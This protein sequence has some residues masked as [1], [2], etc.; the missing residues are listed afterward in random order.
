MASDE[1]AGLA[2]PGWLLRPVGEVGLRM[3]VVSLTEAMPSFPESSVGDVIAG[4]IAA[5]DEGN[6][7]A[8]V[9]Q[10]V[11]DRR[12]REEQDLGLDA[13]WMMSSMSRW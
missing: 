13:C 5:G 1:V 2:F 11:V 3:R 12:G 10:L 7:V 8:E 9:G 4:H 6:L